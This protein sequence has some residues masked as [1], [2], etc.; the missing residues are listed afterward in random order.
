MDKQMNRQ[1]WEEQRRA[2]EMKAQNNEQA[3]YDYLELECK[4]YP[5]K[6]KMLNHFY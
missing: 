1:K 6:V 4:L 2:E 3:A 5:H